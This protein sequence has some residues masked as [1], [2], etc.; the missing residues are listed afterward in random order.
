MERA[1]LGT[2]GGA[3]RDLYELGWA[4]LGGVS[5]DGSVLHAAVLGLGG[6]ELPGLEAVSY[7]DLAALGEAVGGGARVPELVVVWAGALLGGAEAG[8]G[9]EG[10]GLAGRVGVLVEGVLGLLQEFLG[11]GCLGEARLVLVTEG[12]LAVRG[13]ESPDLVQAGVV[14]LLRSACSEFPGRFSLIDVDDGR[15]FAGS[16]YGALCS[17]E[18]ELAL[19]EGTLFVPRLGRVGL[20]GSLVPPVGGGDWC[21]GVESVGTLEGLGLGVSPSA[22]VALGVGQVRVGVCAAGLNFRDVL[23]ALGVYPGETRIGGE[24]AGVVLEVGP[25]VEGLAVGD[26]VMGLMQDA[27]GPV[28]VSDRKLL[29]GVPEGWSFDEAASV[30]IAFLT[31]YYALVDLAGVQPGEVLLVHGAA[32]GVGMAALQ[33]AEYLG[34]EV[35]ATAHP[36]KW[37]TLEGLGVD[38]GRIASSRSA[39]FKEKFLGVTGGR[40]V[41]VVLDSLAGELV[42]ASLGLLPGGGRFIEMG[43]TDIRDP[44]RVAAEYG[45]VRYRAFDLQEAGGDRIQEMLGELVGLFGRGVLRHLPLSRFDVRRAPEAFRFMREAR[46]VGKI[47]LGM[48]RVLD[49]EGTVLVTGGTGGLGG[50]V[51]RHLADVHG[52]RSLLLVSRG[53][54]DARARWSS[55][56]L[57]RSLGA[58]CG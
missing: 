36:D 40:G 6:V 31:A 48:P 21:L 12:A 14:G 35:F 11:V 25:G 42:D 50:L 28:A 49:R 54:E 23:G 24:G 26:R 19:R 34:V 58:M 53:G 41:D 30:P 22:G 10:G 3:V 5:S 51:A 29:V 52:V 1:A 37:G 4:E 2:R 57:W 39:E 17:E 27:F 44:D 56:G 38:G 9:L 43:K 13:G 33:I 46:H 47:V 18:P 15:S 45:G 7:A 55:V 20:G 8:G 32:G 16:L